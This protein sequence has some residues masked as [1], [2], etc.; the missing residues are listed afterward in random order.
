MPSDAY[1]TDAADA[2]APNHLLDYPDPSDWL[3]GVS[4]RDSPK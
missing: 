1:R 3:D 4:L 2:E